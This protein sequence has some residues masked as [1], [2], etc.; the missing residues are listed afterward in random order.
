MPDRGDGR[1]DRDRARADAVIVMATYNGARFVEEQIASIQRQT[2]TR[3]LLLIRDDGSTDQTH[4]KLERLQEHDP[5]IAFVDDE[6]GKTL[7]P[8]GNFALLLS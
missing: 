6:N 3:W 1:P 2:H 4:R 7:G 5:R 8:K